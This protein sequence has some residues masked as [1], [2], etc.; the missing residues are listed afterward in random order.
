M[1]VCYAEKAEY[2]C[3]CVTCLYAVQQ[4]VGGVYSAE[5]PEYVPGCGTDKPVCAVQASLTTCLA[6]VQ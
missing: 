4:Y 6:A 2:V 5:K 3:V 1:G